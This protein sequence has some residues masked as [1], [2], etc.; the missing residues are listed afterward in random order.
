MP[1]HSAPSIIDHRAYQKL[2]RRESTVFKTSYSA[3]VAFY[4]PDASSRR[5]IF[6]LKS[7]I[8]LG[9]F[10]LLRPGFTYEMSVVIRHH[11]GISKQTLVF[12]SPTGDGNNIIQF[13]TVLKHKLVKELKYQEVILVI[14]CHFFI[15]NER[16]I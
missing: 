11:H 12:C 16:Y 10:A 2:N 1:Q 14:F 8:S 3:Y 7:N 15:V 4:Y 6:V 5:T 9:W 13:V